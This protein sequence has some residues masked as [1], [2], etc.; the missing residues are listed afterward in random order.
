MSYADEERIRET[1]LD[2]VKESFDSCVFSKVVAW[3]ERQ[4]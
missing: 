2:I 1:F 3:S 4:E